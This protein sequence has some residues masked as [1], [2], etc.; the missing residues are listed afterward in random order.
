MTKYLSDSRALVVSGLALLA[1]GTSPASAG[2]EGKDVAVRI[3]APLE[4]SA[5]TA[6]P[7]TITLLGLNIDTTK[8]S[9]EIDRE[10]DDHDGHSG[11]SSGTCSALTTGSA[12]EVKLVDDIEPLV[13]TEVEQEGEDEDDDN[14]GTA[15]QA[16]LQG[17]AGGA[18][19]LLGL[20]IDA[21]GASLEGDHDDCEDGGGQAI[22]LSQLT[23]GQLV[24]AHLD[25]SKLP[26]L[27]ATRLEV[28]NFANQV[29]VEVDD[30]N[31]D[32]VADD[33]DTV[34]VDAAVTV[35]FRT[36]AHKG[37]PARVVRKTVHITKTT[38]GRFVLGGL[39]KGIVTIKLT[40]EI[41]GVKTAARRAVRVL[42][43]TTRTV[44]M[45]LRKTHK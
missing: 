13:A 29:E 16:P 40:R 11:S 36:R 26:A 45:R 12:V 42:P 35:A 39:P 4:A 23:V 37:H 22:D 1:A 25:A 32:A 3:K 6:A 15:V 44:K 27:V 30:E 24:E 9:F 7:P 38:S 17:V 33:D 28:K 8:A 10:D 41:G 18:I 14:D 20:N 2:D 34:S 43:N 5:C 31:G 21:S 19:T